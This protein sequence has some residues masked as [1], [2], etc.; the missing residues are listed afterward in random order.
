MTDQILTDQILTDQNQSTTGLE[1]AIVGMAGR[2]PGAANVEEFWQNLARSVESIVALDEASLEAQGV[3]AETL[4]SPDYVKA[5]GLLDG[6]DQFDAAFF[7]FSPREAEILDPQHRLF[8][9]CA[10]SALENSGHSA[11]AYGGAIGVYGGA[12]M[13]GYLFNLA[14]NSR[15]HESVN[16]YE[17]FIANDKD[18]LAT[19]TAFKLNLEGPSVTVQTACSS[20]LVAV[21]LACQGLLSGEC[22][23]ALAGGVALS[24]QVGYH[25]EAGSIYAPD[26]H[27]RAFDAQ[28]QGT[29]GGN[30][31]GLVVLKRLEEAIAE[32]DTILAVIKG[33][34][35]NN[36][37]SDKVS[38]TAPRIDSQA[39]VI[40]AAQTVAGVTPDTITYLETH[41]TGTP[42]GDPIEIAALTQA[43]RQQTDQVGFCAIGSVKTNIG[44]LDAAAGIASLIKT[45][46]AL[47]HQEIPA[48]LHFEQPNP[49]IDFANS[50][51]YVNHERSPWVS[52]DFP[53]RAGV[54][55]F[56]IGGTNAHVILEAA[57][58]LEPKPASSVPQWL[59]LSAKTATALQTARLN[60]AEY[61]EQHPNLNLA[62]VAYTLRVGRKSFEHRSLIPCQTIP[63][64][65][66]AL[67]NPAALSQVVQSGQNSVVFMFPGQGSQYPGMARS[68]YEQEPVFRTTL[69]QS[70][71]ILKAE[72]D[73]PLLDLIYGNASHQLTETANAQPCLFAIEYALAQLWLAWGVQPDALIGHSLGEYVAAC[74]A[75]VFSLEDALR[76]V[77]HRGRLMQSM[78]TGAMLSVALS[79]EALK[80]YL[81]QQYDLTLAVVNA[82]DL[83]VVSGE[84][85]AIATLEAKLTEA[86]VTCRLLKTSHAFH[87]PAMD[88]MLEPFRAVVQA[89]AL[90]P[91]K[92][93]VI[94]NVTGTW[95]QPEDA[96]NPDY[97][98]RQVRQPVQFAAGLNTLQ[99]PN[100][101]WLEVGAGQTLS[102]FVKA[103]EPN[104]L[105]ITSLPHPKAT[106]SDQMQIQMALGQLWFQGV[107]LNW[108]NVYGQQQPQRLPLPTYPFE[109][110]RYWVEPDCELR[111]KSMPTAVPSAA[112][113]GSEIAIAPD[114][115]DWFYAPTWQRDVS[116]PRS[117]RKSQP[118]NKLRSEDRWLVFTDGDAKQAGLGRAIAQ[119]LEQAG[120]AVVT[121]TI[122]NSFGPLG[123]RQFSLNP[124]QA[125][126]Y[127]A[128]LDDLNLRQ[129]QP[130]QIL[131]L[132]SLQPGPLPLGPPLPIMG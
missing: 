131:Y 36:D 6:V 106:E 34:A 64:A 107:P 79:P 22:D 121:V 28:A 26:G 45:V 16:P 3:A 13:N 51:F 88:A 93:P 78:P 39:A 5:G 85:G 111:L 123:Y 66:A 112:K 20:S 40:Q 55:S 96:T 61:L 108:V 68:L 48:S 86:S 47:Q 82:P 10:W 52:Q 4:D 37:G 81:D 69:D 54:S 35:I 21:H 23:L 62:D 24:R 25:A 90:K 104:A 29:V 30:G 14:L 73:L 129:L 49:H 57:P 12:G 84:A 42:I 128:L 1:I 72:L 113:P 19:R 11:A 76:L 80:P 70:A 58:Q 117:S 59:M 101:L 56:G 38:Y 67:R 41:G 31:V 92:L 89:I 122:G 50:P 27:C 46:L 63:E 95:L 126:G 119:R 130:N 94:S 75:G 74:L 118:E 102:T 109:H 116:L 87:S 114:I 18:F 98:V 99:H 7:G 100:R 120:H 60:L 132:W 124:E 91:P 65:I 44:H 103:V 53:R 17:L 33:S 9:E 110:Q 77:A 83:C 43:F 97:W 8:L 105:T 32:R 115:A 71:A 2:F 15:I 125:S 127:Q